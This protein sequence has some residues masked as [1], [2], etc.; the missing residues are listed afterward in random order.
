MIREKGRG[1]Y[2]QNPEKVDQ[3]VDQKGG[4]LMKWLRAW[5]KRKFH[6]YDIEEL[7]A[8]GWCGCCGKWLPDVIVPEWWPYSLCSDW[9][10]SPRHN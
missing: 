2:A 1:N 7:Q 3:K 6:L 5:I 9:K 8:G 4:E 10:T